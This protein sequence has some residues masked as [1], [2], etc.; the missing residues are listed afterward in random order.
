MAKIRK[1]RYFDIFKI[2]KMMSVLKA[3]SFSAFSTSFTPFP[4]NFIQDL[5][6]F[7]LKTFAE[8]YVIE[9]LKELLG[10][11]SIQ[12]QKGNPYKWKIT[13][14]FLKENSYGAGSQLLDFVV[15]KYGAKGVNTFYA[16]ID[17]KNDALLNLFSSGAHFRNCS[18]EHISLIDMDKVKNYAKEDKFVYRFFKNSDAFK[19]AEI[20][21][22][23][24]HTPF[25]Y[26]LS[27]KGKEFR[28][29]VFKGLSRICS[30]K[31]VIEDKES[32]KIVGYF[33]I[34]TE[35]NCNFC[36]EVFVYQHCLCLLEN[37]IH[38]ANEQISRRKKDYKLYFYNRKYQS[39]FELI[40]E[41]LKNSLKEV[42]FQTLMVKDYY[43][44]IEENENATN[45]A[46]F[47]NEIRTIN[48]T[49]NNPL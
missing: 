4:L 18:S 30:Y 26:S 43:K 47:F 2:K 8:S 32:K 44:R 10:V 34:A 20:Y 9:D 1:L 45:T 35:D 31:Y 5:L 38:Y 41:Q 23:L 11:I 36:L 46:I 6:P 25:R 7:R 19:V 40:N 14:L 22:D 16:K 37:V 17:G 28:D 12:S 39:N 29:D 3:E 15:S 21:N 13:N 48:K 42:A 27:K 33:R 49:I 24:I